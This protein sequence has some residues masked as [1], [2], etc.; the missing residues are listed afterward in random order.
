ME[1]HTET[2]AG[3]EKR[4]Y[5]GFHIMTVIDCSLGGKGGYELEY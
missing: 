3:E 1:S 2:C 5:Y 4:I